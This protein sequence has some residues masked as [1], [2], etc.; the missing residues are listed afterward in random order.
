MK[1]RII[2]DAMND[3]GLDYSTWDPKELRS[4]I[5]GRFD[6]SKYYADLA[7]RELQKKPLVDSVAFHSC[8][9]IAKM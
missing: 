5:R 6:C 2:V 7:V 9:E 4:V 1:V 8:K 3:L